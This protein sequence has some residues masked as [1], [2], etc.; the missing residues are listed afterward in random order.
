MVEA[1]RP[2]RNGQ[3]LLCRLIGDLRFL[4]EYLPHTLAAGDGAGQHHHHHGHH[5][6]G[7]EDLRHIGEKGDEVAGE[8]TA[9][10]HIV[11]ADPQHRHDGAAHEQNDH[12]HE[13]YNKAESFFRHGL[14]SLVAPG[15]FILFH[16]LPNKGLHHPDGV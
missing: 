6:Q 13:H 11:A 2:V 9:L 7:N 10:V 5:H 1:D 15:K 14:E 4:I 3:F 16:I 12:R 8:Q